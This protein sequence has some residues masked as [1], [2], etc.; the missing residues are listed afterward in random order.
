MVAL[1][2]LGSHLDERSVQ[3][4]ELSQVVELEKVVVAW[5]VPTVETW[6]TPEQSRGYQAIFGNV[7]RQGSAAAGATF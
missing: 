2:E 4:M 6:K 3:Q 1:D 5:E 7:E